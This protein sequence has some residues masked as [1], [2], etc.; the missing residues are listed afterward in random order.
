MGPSHDEALALIQQ[1]QTGSGRKGRNILQGIDVNNLI[2]V[3]I[4]F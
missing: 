2:E 4:F 1:S 3:H